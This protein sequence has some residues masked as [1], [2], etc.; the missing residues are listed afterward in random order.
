MST[1]RDLDTI[2][3][4]FERESGLLGVQFDVLK[5]SGSDALILYVSC[6]TERLFSIL[7]KARASLDIDEP[8][9][10]T[11]KARGTSNV[12]D[13]PEGQLLLRVLAETQNVNRYSFDSDFFSRYTRSV[14]GAEARI[15]SNANHVVLG[16]RGAGKSMLLL[17]AWHTRQKAAKPSAWVDMQVYS[18]RSDEQVAADI[19]VSLLEQTEPYLG[20]VA[21]HRKLLSE[22]KVQQI[23]VSQ[24]R[25]L[26]PDVRR[27]LSGFS[28]KGQDL[29]IFLDDFHVVDPSLQP[30]ILDVIY[31]FARGN[32][33]FI[34]ISA[35]E[36]FV[37]TFDSGKKHGLEIPQ[38]AQNISLD[39]NL[40]TPD[41][42]TSHIEAILD[43]H[44]QYAGLRSVRRLCTSQDVIPRLTWVAAGVPRDALNLFSQALTTAAVERRQRVSVSNV[45]VAS[46]KTLSIKLRDLETDA[47]EGSDEL[48]TLLQAVQHFC[49]TQKRKNA[50]LVEIASDAV[51]FKNLMRLVDLRLLHVISEGLTVGKAGRKYLGLILDYGFYTG[52]RAAQSVDL[53][54]KQSKSV[55]YK[56]L[57]KLPVFVG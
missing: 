15:I 28:S 40:T 18:G 8:P 57:R 13:G 1:N 47:S 29:F 22:L 23:S 34:K 54:N 45:N 12:L 31:S 53:F 41:R 33:I 4:S 21:A 42:A 35:I 43:S 25:R 36:T 48:Q 39:Y 7:E 20:D 19:I 51:L 10:A 16:R 37:R 30:T 17:Y 6:P 11:L 49:I 3:E 38:D 32:R 14:S 52:V 50:F 44:A 24:I 55:A 2:R 46:S 26:L 56:D 9:L 5:R 27:L